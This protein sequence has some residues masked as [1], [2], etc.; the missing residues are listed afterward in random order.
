MKKKLFY[1]VTKGL[2]CSDNDFIEETTGW[3]DIQVY[4]IEDNEPKMFFP[5]EL[6]N[7]DSTEEEI[8][9]YLDDNGYGD[10]EYE[11]KQL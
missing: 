6:M 10:D 2:T 3:K 4:T 11:F 5:L 8:Q 7:E 9:N 1:V